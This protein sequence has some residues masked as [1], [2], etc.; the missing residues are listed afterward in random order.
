MYQC[1]IF[2]FY[3][4]S[5]LTINFKNCR[6]HQNYLYFLI[7]IFH[8]TSGHIHFIMRFFLFNWC[9]NFPPNNRHLRRGSSIQVSLSQ[10]LGNLARLREHHFLSR[11]PE[12]LFFFTYEKTFSGIKF[13][14]LGRSLW[15]TFSIFLKKNLDFYQF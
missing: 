3:P 6:P 7:L 2:V 13:R 14:V 15:G 9:D 8:K 5:H 4:A 1:L 11:R 12:P 10:H